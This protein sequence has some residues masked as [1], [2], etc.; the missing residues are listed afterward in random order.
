MTRLFVPYDHAKQRRNESSKC[1][2]MRE[3]LEHGFDGERF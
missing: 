1:S 3:L 2:L